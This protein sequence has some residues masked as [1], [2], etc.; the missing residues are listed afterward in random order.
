MPSLTSVPPKKEAMIGL[1]VMDW[2]WV[3]AWAV[4]SISVLVWGV[5]ITI[6]PSTSGSLAQTLSAWK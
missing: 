3:I 6:I 1:S 4:F 5:R 2:I